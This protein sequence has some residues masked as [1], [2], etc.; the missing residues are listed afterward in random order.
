[1]QLEQ[2]LVKTQTLEDKEI[3]YTKTLAVIKKDNKDVNLVKKAI[4]D[5]CMIFK[6]VLKLRKP[7]PI[8]SMYLKE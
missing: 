1:M 7:S 8:Y 6:E 3:E 2:Q 5:M 4:M